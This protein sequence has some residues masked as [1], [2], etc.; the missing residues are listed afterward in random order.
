MSIESIVVQQK[1]PQAVRSKTPRRAQ[2]RKTRPRKTKPTKSRS[3]STPDVAASPDDGFVHRSTRH[4]VSADVSVRDSAQVRVLLDLADAQAKVLMTLFCSSQVFVF[5]A[6]EREEAIVAANAKLLKELNDQV[7]TIV[8]S[9]FLQSFV[10]VT[11]TRRAGQT[12][13]QGAE[14]IAL[15]ITLLFHCGDS[16]L[17]TNRR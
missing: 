9:S 10:C 12:A 1:S 8:V 17:R 6:R 5:Q 11:A 15:F 2:T 16:K 13:I 4:R 3:P 7:L 14:S